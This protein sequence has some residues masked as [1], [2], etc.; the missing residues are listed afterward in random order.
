M[1]PVMHQTRNAFLYKDD[2][3]LMLAA[4][5]LDERERGAEAVAR[6]DLAT[7]Q[8]ARHC[9]RSLLAGKMIR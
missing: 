6:E 9:I 8:D 1:I 5:L 3:Y 2:R 7:K 4:K